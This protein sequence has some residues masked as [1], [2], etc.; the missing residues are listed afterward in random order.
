[1]ILLAVFLARL[2]PVYR[3][4]YAIEGQLAQRFEASGPKTEDDAD[5]SPP[6]INK[7]VQQAPVH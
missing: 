3:H 7:T 5:L 6:C 2:L 4:L 1:M